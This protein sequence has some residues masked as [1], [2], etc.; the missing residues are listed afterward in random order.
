MMQYICYTD[1]VLN[2]IQE[3]LHLQKEKRIKSIEGMKYQRYIE[4]EK[5][6][7]ILMTQYAKNLSKLYVIVSRKYQS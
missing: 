7:S 2:S 5:N 4:G 1:Y 3:M 6:L